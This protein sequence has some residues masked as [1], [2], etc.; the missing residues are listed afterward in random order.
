[1]LLIYDYCQQAFNE[2][3]KMRLLELCVFLRLGHCNRHEGTPIRYRTDAV[4]AIVLRFIPIFL[5]QVGVLE[6]VSH[7]TSMR[8]SNSPVKFL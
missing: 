7:V 8:T 4:A 1:M 3:K 5:A 2:N 6:T